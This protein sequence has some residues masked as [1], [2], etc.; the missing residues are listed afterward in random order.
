[1]NYNTHVTFVISLESRLGFFIS[2]RILVGISSNPIVLD[3]DQTGWIE[4]GK[5]VLQ[6]TKGWGD[7]MGVSE[8]M[9]LMGIGYG[10]ITHMCACA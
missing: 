5:G 7:L 1:M 4:W 3:Y 8:V 10:N 6:Q 2:L 9:T